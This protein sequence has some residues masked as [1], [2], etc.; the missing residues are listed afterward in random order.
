MLL[1]Y[2]D[3]YG[4]NTDFNMMCKSVIIPMEI[5]MMMKFKLHSCGKK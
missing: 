1:I 2:I 3:V 5:E 4:Q